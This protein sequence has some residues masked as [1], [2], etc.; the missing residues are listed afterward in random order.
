M[1]D[2]AILLRKHW[3][4]PNDLAYELYL[5]FRELPAGSSQPGTSAGN[6]GGTSSPLSPSSPRPL[7]PRRSPGIGPSIVSLAPSVSPSSN[8]T[9]SLHELRHR[10]EEAT[11]AARRSIGLPATPSL[12]SAASAGTSPSVTQAP[13]GPVPVRSQ[14]VSP[15]AAPPRNP[16]R[17]GLHALAAASQAIDVSPARSLPQSDQYQSLDPPPKRE[18]YGV[19]AHTGGP[20]ESFAISAQSSA[21]PRLPA[22]IAAKTPTSQQ[23]PDTPVRRVPFDT[24]AGSS[25]TQDPYLARRA[26]PGSYPED[27]IDTQEMW[28]ERANQFVYIGPDGIP[29]CQTSGSQIMPGLGKASQMSFDGGDTGIT[30]GGDQLDIWN[31]GALP[32]SGNQIWP[33][34][35]LSGYLFADP[36]TSCHGITASSI[37][38][39]ADQT[40]PGSGKVT[41][42]YMD[43]NGMTS[44]QTLSCENW[45]NI[46]APTETNCTVAFLDGTLSLEALDC[47]SS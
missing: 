2:P 44:D 39:C 41:T 23:T 10:L 16:I 28:G 37:S 22:D 30:K 15:L 3:D 4:N 31:Y 6:L 36:A 25:T 9:P 11:T 29:G 13:S 14:A 46:T 34:K 7:L 33:A 27:N 32:I 45:Y 19:T 20:P 17:E 18:S 42:F 38:P 5:L 1:F 43:S 35:I 12:F 26:D 40:N 24:R 8:Q 21:P 47:P